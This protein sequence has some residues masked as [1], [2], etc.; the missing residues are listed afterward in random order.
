MV[1]VYYSYEFMKPIGQCISKMTNFVLV[2]ESNSYY[3]L[4]K[5]FV[6]GI[7]QYVAMISMKTG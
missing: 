4:E 7:N 5:M 2:K 1:K 3:S 6:C